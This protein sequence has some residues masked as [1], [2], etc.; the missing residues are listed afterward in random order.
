MARTGCLKCIQTTQAYVE[1]N[2]TITYSI[3]HV[4]HVGVIHDSRCTYQVR[5][6]IIKVYK[7]SIKGEL[8]SLPLKDR[9]KLQAALQIPAPEAILTFDG[10]SK[11]NPGL[12]RAGGCL[13]ISKGK[14]L[15]LFAKGLGN[16]TN[17]IAEYVALIK[18]L[19]IA[20]SQ[21]IKTSLSKGT[22]S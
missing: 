2:K 17:N 12:A 19:D 6:A 18:G 21:G 20:R 8:F 15:I 14:S 11:N 3:F 1:Q 4:I 16:A 10:A 7:H 22:P 13:S 9:L 5:G